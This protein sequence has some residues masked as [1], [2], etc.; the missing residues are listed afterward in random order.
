MDSFGRP[1]PGRSK[2]VPGDGLV[3][4]KKNRSRSLPAVLWQGIKRYKVLQ[5]ERHVN[6]QRSTTCQ[7]VHART[8]V[9]L[10]CS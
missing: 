7:G 9:E 3:L 10:K 2:E 8:T 5:A 6:D 4:R 1:Q